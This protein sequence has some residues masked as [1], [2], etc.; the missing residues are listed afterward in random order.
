LA[1]IR[2]LIYGAACVTVFVLNWQLGEFHPLLYP[3]LLFLGFSSAIMAHNHNHLSVFK[4]APLNLIWTHFLSFFYG[5]PVTVWV[6]VHNQNHHKFTNRPGDWSITYRLTARNNFFAL[7]TYNWLSSTVEMKGAIKYFWN[8]RKTNRKEFIL[9]TIEYFVWTSVMI[10]FLVWDWKKTVMFIIIP[11]QFT[12]FS[13]HSFNYIQHVETDF[14]SKWNHS[15]NFVA[16][17][18][19]LILFNNGFHTMHHEVPHMHWSLLP[20]AH[21]KIEKK[22]DKRLK[23]VDPFWYFIRTYL[24][25]IKPPAIK[26]LSKVSF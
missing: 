5:H 14:A 8:L 10:F 22:I 26:D 9:V 6:P 19:N 1:D 24:F 12:L 17:M 15:R 25:G 18:G 20:D 7:F 4:Y 23:E 16:K 3:A 2:T 13:I 21:K 11:G